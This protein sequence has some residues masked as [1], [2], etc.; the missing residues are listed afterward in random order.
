MNINVKNLCILG[1]L[2]LF[3]I[4]C[5]SVSSKAEEYAK[6]EYEAAVSFD[7]AKA[8]AID[9]EA[10]KYYESL[11]DEDKATYDKA[12]RAAQ[13]KYEAEAKKAA[14]KAANA[15]GSILNVANDVAEDMNE[16]TE[17]A[18]ESAN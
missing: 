12:F 8:K 11:S 6:K 1:L 14:E 2:G 15:M 4:S 3:C 5:N 16:M 17:D 7:F 13:E 9:E 10:T 18:E